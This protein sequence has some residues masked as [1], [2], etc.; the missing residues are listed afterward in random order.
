MKGCDCF[1]GVLNFI[2]ISQAIYELLRFETLKIGHTRAHTHTH[3]HTS[4][5]QLKIKFLDVLDYSEYSDTNISI[6]FSQKH[7][8]L[9]EEAKNH[10]FSDKLTN[11]FRLKKLTLQVFLWNI[12]FT[13]LV[14]TF[15]H[16]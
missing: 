5:R 10:M 1:T 2:L 16:Y 15:G 8:F 9:S 14:I 3:T 11:K 13:N 6:F 7:S 12:F 4:G